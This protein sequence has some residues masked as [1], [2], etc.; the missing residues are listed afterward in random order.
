[1]GKYSF[2]LS[3]ELYKEYHYFKKQIDFDKGIISNLLKFHCGE[4]L[5]NIKQLQEIGIDGEFEK[6]TLI[7]LRKS[8][9]TNQSLTDLANKT[10]YKL[11]L[12]TDSTTFP[13]VNINAD[14]ITTSV[15]GCHY[16]DAIRDKAIK[17]IKTICKNAKVLYLHDAHLCKSNEGINSLKSI[18]PDKNV[19]IVYHSNHLTPDNIADLSAFNPKWNFKNDNNIQTHHDRYIIVDDSVEIVLSSGFHYLTAQS[20]ELTYIVRPIV[21]NRLLNSQYT[22]I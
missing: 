16:R 3:N 2:V 14:S 13:Y 12:C 1:M 9:F 6:S 8:G 17:H 10:D 21:N 22:N 11:I 7:S 20:K 18:L 5:T 15:I 4:F 19:D